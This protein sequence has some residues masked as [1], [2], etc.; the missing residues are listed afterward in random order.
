MPNIL[1]TFAGEGGRQNGGEGGAC[2]V[3]AGNVTMRRDTHGISNRSMQ[4]SVIIVNYNTK[5]LTSE[6]IDSVFEKT[7]DVDFE[8]ILV[9]NASTDGSAEHFALDKRITF[10]A[11]P[12]NIGFG[13][14]NNRGAEA[15]KGEYLLFLNPDTLLMNDAISKM[16]EVMEGDE[17]IGICGG[18]LY[19]GYGEP[20]HSYGYI[21]QTFSGYFKN[22][23]FPVTLFPGM[24]EEHNKSDRVKSVGYI[25]GADLMIRHSVFDHV[26]G[27]CKEMFMYYEDVDLNYKVKKAGY[28]VMSVP[29]ARI[30][31]LV[32][33]SMEGGDEADKTRR[34]RR[35]D[36]ESQAVFLREHYRRGSALLLLWIEKAHVRAKILILRLLRKDTS[37]Y[38]ELI[39]QYKYTEQ[40]VRGGGN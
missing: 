5:K 13:R 9:D 11:S 35:M 33:K 25:T 22:I 6:C 34:R 14:A 24:Y 17:K 1:R 19:D 21:T 2:Q 36:A 26:G 12:E 37:A 10:I 16:A 27:F 39:R 32:G 3:P 8:V 28:K 15:G 38:E 31:H 7:R 40:K 30:I 29:E 20:T 4:V 23:F 18:N